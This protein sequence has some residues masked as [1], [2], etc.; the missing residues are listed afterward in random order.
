MTKPKE[1]IAKWPLNKNFN[2]EG[3]K[4]KEIHEYQK[5]FWNVTTINEK[6]SQTEKKLSMPKKCVDHTC[7]HKCDF[8]LE[9]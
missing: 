6:V 1:L 3:W 9:V 8:L 4:L 5:H 7:D 2:F